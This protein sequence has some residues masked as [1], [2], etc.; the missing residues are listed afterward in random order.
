MQAIAK[1]QAINPRTRIYFWKFSFT[2]NRMEM[3]RYFD[4]VIV[5]MDYI[6]ILING[7]TLCKEQ[8]VDAT[9][10][11]NLTT[12]IN[13]ISIVLPFMDKTKEGGRGGMIV[14]IN[15]VTG[16]DP[17]PVFCVYSAAK[18]GLLGFTRSLA[19][20]VISFN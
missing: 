15:S 12:P 5:Q 14:N 7:P 1:L 4:E 8:D 10:N 13:V 18:F 19:V 3:K 9:I 11:I 16:L 2:M 6:D 20:S 17:S